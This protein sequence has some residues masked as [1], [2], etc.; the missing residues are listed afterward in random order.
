MSRKLSRKKH[1]KYDFKCSCI[2]A[3]IK[4]NIINRFSLPHVYLAY[5]IDSVQFIYPNYPRLSWY[6]SI[7]DLQNYDL[8]IVSDLQ[9]KIQNIKSCQF[10]TDMEYPDIYCTT[11]GGIYD[12]IFRTF[13]FGYQTAPYNGYAKA[14]IYNNRKS[15]I[16]RD[17]KLAS[18]AKLKIDRKYERK[19]KFSFRIDNS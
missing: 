1:I 2:E 16:A 8:R 13:D 3:F 14:I 11:R 18:F 5:K 15:F 7:K 10:D 9:E 12:I 4:K 17:M 19:I 6:S